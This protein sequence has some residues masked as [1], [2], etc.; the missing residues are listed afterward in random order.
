MVSTPREPAVSKH[1]WLASTLDGAVCG[2]LG[3]VPRGAF[4]DRRRERLWMIV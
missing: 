3:P 2:P 1:G 4:E